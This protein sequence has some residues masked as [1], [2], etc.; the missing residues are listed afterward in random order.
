MF[1][2]IVDKLRQG[3]PQ[4]S[5]QTRSVERS[6]FTTKN[7]TL[8]SYRVYISPTTWTSSALIQL[9]QTKSIEKANKT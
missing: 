5:E 4:I 3:W 2:A 7:Q 6:P 9:E 1:K 8:E